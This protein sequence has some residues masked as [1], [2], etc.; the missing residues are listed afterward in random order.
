MRNKTILIPLV[1]ALIISVWISGERIKIERSNNVVE[2]VAD[3]HSFAEISTE[4]LTMD[5]ILD[6]LKHLGVT[7]IAL[8]EWTLVDKIRLG[9][10]NIALDRA[11]LFEPA[12]FNPVVVDQ[13]NNSGFPVVPRLDIELASETSFLERVG[14]LNPN[15]IIFKGNGSIIDGD[16]L[17]ALDARIGLVEF[18]NQGGINALASVDNA[19]RVHGISQAEMDFLDYNRIITRYLRGVRERNIRV[20]YLR[21]FSGS[22]GWQSTQTLISDLTTEL[23]D[24]G[25]T[26]GTANPYRTWHP[27]VFSLIIVALGIILGMIQLL[28]KWVAFSPTLFWILVGI[29]WFASS[30]LLLMDLN[31][32]QQVMALLGSIVFPSLALTQVFAKKRSIIRS[33]LHVAMISLLGSLLVVGMLGGSDYLIKL[34]E[35][36]GVKLMH[37]APVGITFIYGLIVTKLPF[38]SGQAIIDELKTAWHGSIPVKYLVSC[39]IA[40]VIVAIYLLRTDNFLLP[41]SQLEITFREGLEQLLIVRPRTKEFL[42]GHPVLVLVLAAKRKHPVLLAIAVIGQ[43][44]IVNTFTHVHTPL[45]LSGLRVFYGLL[46]GY[47]IGWLVRK[48]WDALKGRSNDDSSFRLL[49]I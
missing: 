35:F 40:A 7:Q 41:V 8:D 16:D 33:Y 32:G 44:S 25:Y 19:V 11:Q 39:G 2:L 17:L 21:P 45:L 42:L 1:I 36:R 6:T 43:L 15:L 5:T 18:T 27:S 26:I 14:N 9:S 3:Y 20:L 30:I 4:E 28:N 29:S 22:D 37:I 38:K 12:G 46:F 31:F 48:I 49:R 24:A 10:D 23:I 13:I 34:Q 47:L